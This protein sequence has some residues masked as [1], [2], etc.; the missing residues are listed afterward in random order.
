MFRPAE[1]NRGRKRGVFDGVGAGARFPVFAGTGR[2]LGYPRFAA[3]A[4][5]RLPRPVGPRW[6]W[7][8]GSGTGDRRYF[9]TD[10]RGSIVAL[11]D[12][13][14]GSLGTFAY[15]P[16]GESAGGSFSRFGYT[17]QMAIPG[18]DL[19][20]FK[21]R[22]YAPD[23][24]RFLQPDPI[25]FAGGDLNLYAYVG[26][27]P[28]NFTD[29]TGL[30]RAFDRCV[31]RGTS[32]TFDC[33]DFQPHTA[34]SGGGGGGFG[35]EGF[36]G[37]FGG[38]NLGD[39]GSSGDIEDAANAEACEV[40]S[41]ILEGLPGDPADVFANARA[42]AADILAQEQRF[43]ALL[44]GSGF[45]TNAAFSAHQHKQ[46]RFARLT[47]PGGFGDFKRPFTKFGA[48][49]FT[50]DRQATG[51]KGERAGNFHAGFVGALLGIP[52]TAILGGGGV[53]NVSKGRV[54]ALKDFFD[55]EADAEDIRAGFAAAR[56]GCF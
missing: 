25:G 35:A 13:A 40:D 9:H 3:G 12:G 48:E 37:G 42:A 54:G 38:L 28:I 21:A 26:N 5:S 55:D 7:Y 29:P 16:Y 43:R 23:L 22:A 2:S 14:G 33:H 36:N 41:E 27:D 52:Q 46:A 50:H 15:G 45:K 17:G 44:E 31:R 20:H 51:R 34:V 8:E 49:A 1:R 24:G 11:S 18:T 56:A 19:L 4:R 30:M 47:H 6:V 39:L 53:L 10:A 32:N